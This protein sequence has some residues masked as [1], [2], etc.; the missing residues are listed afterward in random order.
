MYTIILVST[1]FANAQAIPYKVDSKITFISQD[2][3]KIMASKATQASGLTHKC[4]KLQN[5]R[6]I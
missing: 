1:L 3:C 2:A 5:P 6:S 4:V